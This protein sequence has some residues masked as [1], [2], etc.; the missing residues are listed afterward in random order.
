MAV[1]PNGEID[2]TNLVELLAENQKTLVSLMH[3][4]NE[5]GTVLDLDRIVPIQYN[6]LL[7]SD[8]VQSIGKKEID[9]ELPID[10]CSQCP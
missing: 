6:A 7:H 5:I 2:I 1:K 10:F 9:T 8:T 4:N 3:V